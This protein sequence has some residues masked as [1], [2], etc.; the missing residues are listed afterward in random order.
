MRMTWCNANDDMMK[1]TNKRNTWQQRKTWKPS[2]ELVSGHYNRVGCKLVFVCAG[3]Q[4]L[5]ALS[6][7]GLIPWFSKVE[8]NTY[9]TLLRHP[10][11]F[12][13]KTNASSRGSRAGGPLGFRPPLD[14]THLF[15]VRW[16]MTKKWLMAT[17]L[18]AV[19]HVFAVC[20][21]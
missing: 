9:S 7:I 18:F 17:R 5:V 11:L 15:S 19:S 12:K 8:W 14:P 1:A 10:F 21:L 6:P 2:G 20:F 4:W 3:I 13:G 16:R